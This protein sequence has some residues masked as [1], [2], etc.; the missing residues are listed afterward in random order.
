[1]TFPDLP[2]LLFARPWILWFLAA[3]PVVVLAPYFR[4]R[5]RAL[6][7]LFPALRTAI[8]ILLLLTLAGPL[9]S[10]G[11][12]EMTTVFVVDR[13]MSVQPGSADAANRWVTE[14]LATA[15]AESSA[16]VV[17]FGAEPELTVP[18]MPAS[19][20]GNDWVTTAPER[21]YGEAT[22]LASALTLARSIPVGEQRRIVVLSDGAENIGQAIE[23]ADLAAL[24]NVPI[25]VVPLGGVDATDV[26]I[27]QVTGPNALWQGDPLSVIAT[28]GSGG[29][30][31]AT[32]ELLVDGAV[33]SRE[34]VALDP[35]QTVH[36][37]TA[38]ALPAGFHR[39]EVRVGA[40]AD[41]DRIAQNNAGHLGVVVREQPAVLLVAPDGSDPTRL[42]E[43]LSANGADLTQVPPSGIPVRLSELAGYDSIV[44]DNVSAWDLS[45]EQQLALVSHTRSGHGLVVVGG[46]ASYG[47][48]SYAGTELEAALPVTVKVVDGQQRPS[49]AVL[50]VM[51]KSGSMSYN[52]SQSSSAKIDLAKDGV[53]TAAS[54]LTAGDQIGVIAFNDEPLWALPMTALTG[55]GDLAR[56]EQA[57]S[58]VA[59]DGGTELYPALQVAYDSLRNVDADVRHIILLSDGKSRSGSRETYGTLVNDIG[60]DDITLSTVALGTDADLELLEFLSV[61]GNGRYHVANTPEEIP[62]V[63]FQEAQSAGS[64]SVL[65]GAF[66]P[67]QQQASPILNNID[68][69]AMPP[70]E[71]Y[72]FAEGRADA[73]V[74]LTSDRGDPLLVKWQ[75]GLGRV[76]A[77]TADD[78]G[79]YATGWDA[80]PQYD[81]FWGNTLRWTLPD[82]GTRAVTGSIAR[83]GAG[84]TITLDAQTAGGDSLDL[85]GATLDVTSPDGTIASLSPAQVGPGLYEATLPSPAPGAYALSLAIPTD[86]PTQI[87][88]AGAI[89]TSP[90]W[91][92]AP[93]GDN[94]LQ[95]LAGRTGGV[96]RSLDTPA[97]A[98]LFA[99]RSNALAGPGSVEPVWPYPL[100][101]ALALFVLDIALR[102]SERYGRRRPPLDV[103]RRVVR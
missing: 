102:M 82:P 13:S 54:A 72:N 84:A 76:V 100:I 103:T 33:V 36:T 57:I 1:M 46:S 20:I 28:V 98:D 44:L 89:Q 30:G 61:E 64:Q 79:D 31:T 92:P 66:T 95:T 70:V 17:T 6:P 41:L 87:R 32:V 52:P 2:D 81:Q 65:R 15:N 51:D 35:G 63:T 43:A 71:G 77:W 3:I 88:T 50:I 62:A 96:V 34:T 29:G 93:E 80:W 48:G 49:V 7:E 22:D 75:L 59:A 67:V 39:V 40:G 94:L 97:S 78:G 85:T 8:L 18:A 21:G 38:P 74:D 12:R 58:P 27:E 101:A 90:E 5:R 68:T 23:Q 69:A 45:E 60:N 86:P 73:Q 53:V 14:A 10:H 91:L 56:V 16:A 47:P 25:D 9:I 26:R 11:A 19:R 42:R 24:D 55:Q 99:S 83:D 4:G 37:V